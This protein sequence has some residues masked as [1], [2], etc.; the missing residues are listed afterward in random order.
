M[1]LEERECRFPVADV[2]G[3]LTSSEGG[4]AHCGP[5]AW[6]LPNTVPVGYPGTA[7]QKCVPESTGLRT[8]HMGRSVSKEV[9]R[10]VQDFCTKTFQSITYNTMKQTNKNP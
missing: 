6:T 9:L 2:T 5:G 1:A 7:L 10:C 3:Q 4:N 8:V